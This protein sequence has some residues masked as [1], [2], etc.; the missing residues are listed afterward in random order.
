[1]LLVHAGDFFLVICGPEVPI[2]VND[3]TRVFSVAVVTAAPRQPHMETPL[4]TR[5]VSKYIFVGCVTASKVTRSK[6]WQ[7]SEVARVVSLA[8]GSARRKRNPH[9]ALKLLRPVRAESRFRVQQQD[10]SGGCGGLET[11]QIGFN[12]D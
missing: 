1:M 5:L 10:L 11:L 8:A 4:D 9:C 2:A 12:L 7:P 6:R 3:V